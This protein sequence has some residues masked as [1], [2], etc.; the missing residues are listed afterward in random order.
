[1]VYNV[2]FPK[3]A[4]MQKLVYTAVFLLLP[5]SLM[6]KSGYIRENGLVVIDHLPHKDTTIFYEHN[7]SRLF[8]RSLKEHHMV[9]GVLPYEFCPFACIDHYL[10]QAQKKGSIL[11]TEMY[12]DIIPHLTSLK[13]K[14]IQFPKKVVPCHLD[15]HQG[16]TL[17]DD[18]GLFITDWK[19]TAMADP[20]F[21][22]AIFASE[23]HMQDEEMEQLLKVYLEKTPSSDEYIHLFVMRILADIRWSLW[24]YLQV[25][26]T[27]VNEPYRVEAAPYMMST[28]ERLGK[29][30]LLYSQE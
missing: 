3:G 17:Y 8:S 24:C 11:P 4:A 19:Y 6:G 22:L 1:M 28:L 27:S 13:K 10:V 5:L 12:T 21:D 16:N 7:P 14:A 25:S 18:K 15:L 23:R 26:T 29:Y 2:G 9:N 20:F 30:Q